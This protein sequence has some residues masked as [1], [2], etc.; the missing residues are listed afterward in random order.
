M[1]LNVV[2][3]QIADQLGLDTSTCS[4]IAQGENSRVTRLGEW[5]IKTAPRQA[6]SF[7]F[8]KE[9]DALRTLSVHGISVPGTL[10]DQPM[11][12]HAIPC[13]PP[14]VSRRFSTTRAL[15][16]QVALN[17]RCLPQTEPDTFFS[18]D[19]NYQRCPSKLIG[20]NTSSNSP[21]RT[22]RQSSFARTSP[23]LSKPCKN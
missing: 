2:E 4:T 18:V 10:C 7:Q 14:P 19:S 22:C 23:R 16:S 17:D 11:H 1:A 12:R 6:T 8:Q 3:R 20:L 15:V 13:S 21:P 9:A 5:V